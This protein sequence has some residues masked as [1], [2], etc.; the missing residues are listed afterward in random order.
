MAAGVTPISIAR[1]FSF[2]PLASLCM[3]VCA[4]VNVSVCVKEKEVCS[5]IQI[6]LLNVRTISL[7]TH[8]NA[9]G[10]LTEA[11]Q[12]ATCLRGVVFVKPVGGINYYPVI[13]LK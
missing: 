2:S 12:V 8:S 7:P 4:S 9:T 10:D 1:S 11:V 13:Y 6:K 3:C 5:R